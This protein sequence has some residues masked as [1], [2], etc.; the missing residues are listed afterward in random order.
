MKTTL[1]WISLYIKAAWRLT[2]PVSACLAVLTLIYPGEML[3]IPLAY[4]AVVMLYC[5][6]LSF[7]LHPVDKLLI[8]LGM[9]APKRLVAMLTGWSLHLFTVWLFTCLAL[10][11]LPSTPERYV[12]A[13]NLWSRSIP[14]LYQTQFSIFLVT[15]GFII[16]WVDY[17]S[18]RLAG[19]P[20]IDSALILI[21]GQACVLGSLPSVMPYVT[22]L[23]LFEG[24]SGNYVL[25]PL[26]AALGITFVVTRVV[27]AYRH[28]SD[29][30][31][32]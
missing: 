2:L 4:F 17:Q 21:L 16:G 23:P 31:V 19:M 10:A 1:S 6:P 18:R 9:S 32:A 27:A 25:G 5:I 30:E 26:A 24:H 7:L 15:L 14:L 3:R 11:Y 22:L 28:L 12:S 29:S 13:F 8:T 20:P